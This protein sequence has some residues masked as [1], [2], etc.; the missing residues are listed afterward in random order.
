MVIILAL[1]VAFGLFLYWTATTKYADEEFKSK[2][3]TFIS[4]AIAMWVFGGLVLL[5][6]VCMRD[7]IEL[8]IAIMKSAS[9]FIKDT[10]TVLLIPIILF[11]V[12]CVFT[13]FW[14]LAVMYLYSSGDIK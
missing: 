8:A 7:R 3:I 13:V 4:C 2:R 9:L 12:T 1:I 6:L 14:I 5:M 11:L 10:W